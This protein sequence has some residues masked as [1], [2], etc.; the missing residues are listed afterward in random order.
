VTKEFKTPAPF[1]K[2][3]QAPGIV[4]FLPLYYRD[5]LAEGIKP[6]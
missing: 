6:R 5:L 2:Y 3:G 4:R 1:D